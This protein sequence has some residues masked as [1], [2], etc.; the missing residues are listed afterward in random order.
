VIVTDKAA[1]AQRFDAQQASV[2]RGADLP[3][4]G[5]IAERM[6]HL[7][8]IGVVDR[9]FGAKGL[10]FIVELLVLLERGACRR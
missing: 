3:Q 10:S 8:V 5:Q 9:G 6:T 2:G 1:V 7:E 4:R